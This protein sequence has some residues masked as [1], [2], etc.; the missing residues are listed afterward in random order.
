MFNS[1]DCEI[2][3]CSKKKNPHKNKKSIISLQ[4]CYHPPSITTD[5]G[6]PVGRFSTSNFKLSF[7]TCCGAAFLE[8]APPY[9]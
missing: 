7:F 9:D 4:P 2:D 5:T 1:K 3:F 8:A 6:V